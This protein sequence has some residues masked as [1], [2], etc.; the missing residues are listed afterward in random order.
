MRA[1]CC[2]TISLICGGLVTGKIMWHTIIVC[3]LNPLFYGIFGMC[4][5]SCQVCSLK[6]TRCLCFSSSFSCRSIMYSSN[7][8]SRDTPSYRNT[9]FL[10]SS[11]PL[12]NEISM[13][14]RAGILVTVILAFSARF[15][16]L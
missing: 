14:T 16:F 10:S 6:L 2:I 4:R 5:L 7:M 1:F 15:R 9:F 3:F 8:A 11:Q 13:S 12:V